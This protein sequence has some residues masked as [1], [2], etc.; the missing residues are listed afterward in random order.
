MNI[1]DLLMQCKLQGAKID[2]IKRHCKLQNI[3]CKNVFSYCTHTKDRGFNL[4]SAGG[5]AVVCNSSHI[6]RYEACPEFVNNG[7][8]IG[9]KITLPVSKES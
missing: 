8:I 6:K 3:L 7:E 1:E 2:E 5:P 4:G 9:Y